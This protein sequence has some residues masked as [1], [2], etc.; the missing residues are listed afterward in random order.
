[1]TPT[2]QQRL[3]CPIC[4]KVFDADKQRQHTDWHVDQRLKRMLRDLNERLNALRV[5]LAPELP[6]QWRARAD[7]LGE[8][9]Q[10]G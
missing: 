10:H 5:N 8:E 6:S 3:I 4:G 9:G 1:M 2:D 7:A